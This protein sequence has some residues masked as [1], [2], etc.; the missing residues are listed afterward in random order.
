[1]PQG[2]G[3]GH[4][5][6]P[7]VANALA[8]SYFGQRRQLGQRRYFSVSQCL[9]VYADVADCPVKRVGEIVAKSTDEQVLCIH[10]RKA[11]SG[12]GTGVNELLVDVMPP[13]GCG[14]NGDGHAV[15]ATQRDICD[16]RKRLTFIEGPAGVKAG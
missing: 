3:A 8:S 9:L 12:V 5:I 15:P 7:C 14:R 16:C 13:A 10:P 2:V 11:G 4:G 6:R 1:M